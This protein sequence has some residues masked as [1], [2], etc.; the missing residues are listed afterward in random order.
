MI[1]RDFELPHPA[2]KLADKM[3]NE[4]FM[5]I[6]IMDEIFWKSFNENHK[7]NNQFQAEILKWCDPPT[8]YFETN[9]LDCR[10]AWSQMNDQAT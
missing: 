9:E 8:V 5:T 6:I 7:M 2:Q 1:Y 4:K 3:V 10:T